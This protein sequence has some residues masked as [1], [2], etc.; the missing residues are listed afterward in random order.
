MAYLEF[1]FRM[2]QSLALILASACICSAAS[3]GKVDFGHD[4]RPI[5][6]KHCTSCH[7]G[8]KEAGGISFVS[9]DRAMAE[10][11]S[12]E[13]PVVPGD[14]AKSDMLRRIRSTDPDEVM[15]K[16][17]HGPPLVRETGGTGRTLDRRRRGMAEPLVL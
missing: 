9:R 10:G 3:P 12:G 17:K 8:V 7:G 13:H 16:P 14:P 5:L 6:T 15:P 1:I 11:E 2:K 4:I